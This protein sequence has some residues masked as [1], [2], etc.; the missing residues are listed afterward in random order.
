MS[1]AFTV[2]VIETCHKVSDGHMAWALGRNKLTEGSVTIKEQWN[3]YKSHSITAEEEKMVAQI[4][5]FLG[6]AEGSL[7]KAAEIMAKSDKKDLNAFMIEELYSSLEPVSGKLSE[8]MDLQ[9]E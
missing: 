8:L 5:G 2:N 7:A 6:I 3:T 1:D 9:L 4:D